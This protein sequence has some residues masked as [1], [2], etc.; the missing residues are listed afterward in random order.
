MPQKDKPTVSAK[1]LHANAF[2]T[3]GY[4][5][6]MHACKCEVQARTPRVTAFTEVM[7]LIAAVVGVCTAIMGLIKVV[8]P[9]VTTLM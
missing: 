4:S 3:R 5:Q 1:A 9:W 6:H 8:E 7:Q 2:E